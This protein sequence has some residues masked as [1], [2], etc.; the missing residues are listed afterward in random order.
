MILIPVKLHYIIIFIIRKIY[1]C[2]MQQKIVLIG[3]P[4]Q[5]N[6]PF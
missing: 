6:R 5:G 4:E 2:G 3:G 1:F